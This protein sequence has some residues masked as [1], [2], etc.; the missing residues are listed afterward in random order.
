MKGSKQ[1]LWS[2]GFGV[3]RRVKGRARQFNERDEG[4][5]PAAP[6][7]HPICRRECGLPNAAIAEADG[8]REVRGVVQ[9]APEFSCCEDAGHTRDLKGGVTD[10]WGM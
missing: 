8:G 5:P 7:E 2:L 6:G 10:G 4:I 3:S 9:A 1:H